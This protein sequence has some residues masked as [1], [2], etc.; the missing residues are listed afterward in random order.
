MSKLHHMVRIMAVKKTVITHIKVIVDFSYAWVAMRSYERRLQ[1]AISTKPQAVLL[2]K[3]VFLK[4]STIME[5]PL[6]RI[7]QAESEDFES[8]AKYYSG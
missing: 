2:L 4:M 6:L 3:T 5:K 7:L 1:R 8:V